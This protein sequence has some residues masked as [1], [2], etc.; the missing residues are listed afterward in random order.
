MGKPSPL[1]LIDERL[2][3]DGGQRD[4]NIGQDGISYTNGWTAS[5]HFNAI[6]FANAS[7][8]ALPLLLV[9]LHLRSYSHFRRR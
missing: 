6:I 7:S 3:F 8:G 5:K 1:N 2:P 4:L 9:S